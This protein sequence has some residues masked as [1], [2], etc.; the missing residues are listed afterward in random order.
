M[1]PLPRS[2]SNLT[3]RR[4]LTFNFQLPP[5]KPDVYYVGVDVGTG[6]ARACIIDT[7]GVILGLSERPINRHELKPNY[8]T[9]SSTEIWNAICFCVKSCLRESGVEPE[10]VFGIGFDATCSLV[11]INEDTELPVA[12]CP[13]FTDKK[14]NIILWMDHRAVDET[15]EINATDDK[16]LKNV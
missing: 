1:P 6:S 7:N 11:A 10:Y 12:V 8:I 4:S 3:L 9:Q 13:D 15:Q 14:E 16:C 5:P 2:H